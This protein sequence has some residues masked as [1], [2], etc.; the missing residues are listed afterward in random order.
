[1]QKTTNTKKH[2]HHAHT[3]HLYIKHTIPAY[4][5]NFTIYILQLTCIQHKKHNKR[6]ADETQTKITKKK[7]HI[8]KRKNNSPAYKKQSHIQMTYILIH[9]QNNTQENEKKKQKKTTHQTWITKKKNVPMKNKNT[10]SIS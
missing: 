5:S 4:A 10:T 2:T 3:Y 1:M 8:C 6:P 7:K 9:T